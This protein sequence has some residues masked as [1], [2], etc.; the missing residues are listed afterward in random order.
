[1]IV[2]GPALT[3]PSLPRPVAFLAGQP[4]ASVLA[5]IPREATARDISLC[6]HSSFGPRV[7]TQVMDWLWRNRV[8]V[9][10]V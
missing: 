9:A 7:S 8:L 5:A 6:L 10:L 2:P 4:A 1:M 3:H